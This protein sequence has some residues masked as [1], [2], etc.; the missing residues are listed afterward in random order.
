MQ[1]FYLHTWED[2]DLLLSGNILEVLALPLSISD[3][4]LGEGRGRSHCN[5]PK[6][7]SKGK[8]VLPMSRHQ[9]APHTSVLGWEGTKALWR[10]LAPLTASQPVAGPRVGKSRLPRPLRACESGLRIS[11]TRPQGQRRAGAH[12]LRVSA[13]H[14][15]CGSC[16]SPSEENGAVPGKRTALGEKASS[17]AWLTAGHCLSPASSCAVRSKVKCCSNED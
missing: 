4:A 15:S 1:L 12:S 8:P 6:E 17:T 11:Q 7:R 5:I 3:L 13:D 10:W 2:G 16:G 9:E 14:G